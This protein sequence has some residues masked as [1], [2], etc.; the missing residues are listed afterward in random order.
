MKKVIVGSKFQ[1]PEEIRFVTQKLKSAGFESYLVGGCVRDLFLQKNPK[2]WDVTTN[3][4][5]EQIQAIFEKTFYENTFGT[6]GVVNETTED[7]TLKVVEVTPY[8]T[9][10]T[11]SD[12]RRPDSVAFSKHIEDDLKRRDF[13]INAIAYDV[14]S[15]K[16]VDLYGGLADLSRGLI[17]AVGNPRERFAEDALRTL[18]AIRF[19]AE[20]GFE[21]E[22]E[23]RQAI[24]D[25]AHGLKEISKERIRDEFIRII[26][27]QN[28]SGAIELC[29][30]LGLLKYMVPDLEKG[31]GIEQN[32]AHAFDVWTHLLKSLA[33]AAKKEMPLHIRIAALFHDIGKPDT[34]RFSEEKKDYTFYGHEV[35]GARM[36][37]KILRDLKFPLD[38]SEKI[39]KLVRWHMFFSDTE[40]I[41]HSAVRRMIA[42]VGK[43]NVWDLMNVRV[44]DRIGTGKPKETPYRLRKYHAMIEEV[45]RDPISVGMLK[46]DGKKI[47]EITKQ[48]PGPR[49]GY[50]LHALL[51][52]VLEDPAKNEVEVLEKI[53]IK[54]SELKTEELQKIGEAGKDRMVE[55]DEKLV[56]EIR[57]KHWV[58]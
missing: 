51:E 25:E 21:I 34:R 42:N 17:R 16:T 28:P 48:P 39:V 46:L 40:K 53:V 43:E 13:T 52:E 30:K 45:M 33:H 8:R 3:A 29:H 10:S 58:D 7:P 24:A 38:L 20:H 26:Q 2:D 54:L 6:V 23:T 50:I 37:E 12:K 5:P 35:V 55:E 44:C 47:M 19:H 41:T 56:K 18:R 31:I 14:E 11:Y 27:S 15:E 9:E 57:G 22:E 1:I 36:T 49:I 4:T 32:Q